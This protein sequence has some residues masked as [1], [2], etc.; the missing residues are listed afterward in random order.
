LIIYLLVPEI[1]TG[2]IVNEIKTRELLT[3]GPG[4]P[5]KPG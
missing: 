4:R 5:G 1:K 3:L 2:N